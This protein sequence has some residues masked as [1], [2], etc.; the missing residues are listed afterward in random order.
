MARTGRAIRMS[1]ILAD[2][3]AASA[4]AAA[5]SSGSA[6]SATS[7]VPPPL[8]LLR[9]N[10]LPVSSSMRRSQLGGAVWPGITSC[11][12]SVG[13]KVRCHAANADA[14]HIMSP[15]A[16][17]SC[18][19]CSCC[20]GGGGGGCATTAPPP[21]ATTAAAP[22]SATPSSASSQPPLRM[23]VL[24]RSWL[25]GGG[26]GGCVRV[27]TA[28]QAV[29]GAAVAG[30]GCARCAAGERV[31]PAE[32]VILDRSADLDLGLDLIIGRERAV[33]VVG[34]EQPRPKWAQP[35]GC[36]AL[37]SPG[38]WRA[39][40]SVRL[41]ADGSGAAPRGAVLKSGTRAASKL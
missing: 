7:T 39:V 2:F 41:Q 38:A 14:A 33:V 34:R 6:S 1:Y 15:A 36:L 20:C 30:L 25:A 5:S 18:C 37:R 35:D 28:R 17:S 8:G 24:L 23:A 27:H 3:S 12:S 16:H 10:S 19:S 29:S 22:S 21:S 31:A 9:A 13:T 4:A 40:S 26:G 11:Q 32:P